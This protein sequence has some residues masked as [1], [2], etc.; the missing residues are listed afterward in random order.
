M[1]HLASQELVCFLD[2]FAPRNIQEY[3]QHYTA[4]NPRIASLTTCGYPADLLVDH[5]TEINLVRALNASCC[6]KSRSDPIP[7]SGVNF[8]G[9]FVK[10]HSIAG[11]NSPQ[12]ES[13][14]VHRETVGVHVPRPKRNAAGFQCEEDL[15]GGPYLRWE[16]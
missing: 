14:L 12:F 8:A 7:V 4:D 1:A 13:A 2:L 9:K 16:C 5:D 11:R 3:S 15:L 6:D 10:R